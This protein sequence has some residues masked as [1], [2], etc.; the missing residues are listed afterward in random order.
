MVEKRS[1]ALS[2]K[3]HSSFR[4]AL[5]L[6]EAK[7]YK[8]ALKLTE[9]ILKKNP[10]HGETLSV[11]G[12]MRYHLNQKDDGLDD[13]KK[14]LVAD[15]DSYICWHVYGLYNRL[16]KNYEEAAK[17][18][19]KALQYDPNNMNVT[20]DLAVLQ[21]QTHQYAAAVV[22]RGK[23]LENSPGYRQH[24]NSLSIAQYLNKDYTAAENTLKKFEDAI[25]KPLPKTDLENSE[26]ALFRNLTIYKSGDV[27]RALEHLDLIADKVS[28]PLS[29][30]EYRAKYLLELGRNKEAEREYRAL[31][32]RNPE[33]RLYLAQLEQS[34]NIEPT[35]IKLRQVLY[36]RLAEKYPR[37]DAI[38]AIP[39]E[40][41]SG[42]EFKSAVSAYLTNFLTRG[43]PSTFVILKP[44]YKDEAK[45]AIIEDFI[46]SQ[47]KSLEEK[48]EESDML[49]WT[50]FYLAQHYCYLRKID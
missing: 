30:M 3:D 18:F 36:N 37:S 49:L 9:Q 17:A 45:Q 24:W 11:R 46:L 10:G 14:G 48:N 43:V 1:K 40:F 27:T 21:V 20:R 13:L 35:N 4:D 8:K 2:S 32:K 47:Y 42:E 34:L 23:L 41:L 5:K 39:L 12:L 26:I 7:Q 29:I 6:Y 16:E 33:N 15:P 19:T 50:T 28:D 25:N 31:V 38:R 22:S 44:F